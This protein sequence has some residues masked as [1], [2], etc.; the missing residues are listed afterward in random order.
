MNEKF[1]N[2]LPITTKTSL[3]RF[4]LVLTYLRPDSNISVVYCYKFIQRL[5]TVRKYLRLLTKKSRNLK[6]S[7]PITQ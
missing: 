1:A 2:M 5:P 4:G 7:F 6:Y 3:K